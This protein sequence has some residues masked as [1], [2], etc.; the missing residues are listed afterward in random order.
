MVA[1]I[2]ESPGMWYQS[3]NFSEQIVYLTHPSYYGLYLRKR[4][5]HAAEQGLSPRAS[6]RLLG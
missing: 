4:V 2:T 1:F 3:M 6:N 5:I